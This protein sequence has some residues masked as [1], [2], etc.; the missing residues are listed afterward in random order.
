MS[1]LLR[2]GEHLPINFSFFL[3]TLFLLILVCPNK[4]FR[5]RFLRKQNKGFWGHFVAISGFI[6]RAFQLL[7][8]IF[9][10]F[11]ICRIYLVMKGMLFRDVFLCIVVGLRV[12]T[13]LILLC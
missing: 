7:S 2:R 8:T 9:F 10:M 3:T 1:G 12:L 4:S 11:G 6:I 13:S 5:L